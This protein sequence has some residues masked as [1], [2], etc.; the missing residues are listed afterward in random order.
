MSI[1]VPPP[2]PISLG[3]VRSETGRLRSVL[4]HRPGRELDRLTPANAAD[5]LFDE[6]PEP[7]AARREHD[8]LTK[9]LRDDGV[10]VVHLE[11]L[12]AGALGIERARVADL[13]DGDERRPAPL[14]NM[15]FVRDTSAW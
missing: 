4:V 10:E 8:A 15:T 7:E 14:P 9:V 3:D 5:L 12:L 1:S 11:D 6:V 2:S 13:I